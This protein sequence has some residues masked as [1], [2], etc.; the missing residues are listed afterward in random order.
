MSGFVRNLRYAARTLLR[1]P[2]FTAAAIAT[3]ALG[4][5][6]CTV[7]FSVF[8]ALVLRPLPFA[9]ASRLVI[10]WDQ[11]PKLG[12]ERLAPTA[13]NYFDYREQSHAFED[14]AAFQ[15]SEL[16]LNEVN[17]AG[18]SAAAPERIQALTVSSNIFSVLGVRPSIGRPF[19]AADEQLGRDNVVLLSNDLWR[20]R[21]GGDAR[22][23]GTSVRLNDR[24]FQ[25]AGVM[26]PDFR[27]TIDTAAPDLWVPLPLTRSTSHTVGA[28]A[29]L[30]RGFSLRQAQSDMNRVAAGV[31]AAYRPYNGPHGEDAGYRVRVIE[32]RDQLFGDYKTSAWVLFGAVLFVLLIACA[33]VANLLVARRLTR[34]REFAIRVALGA[35]RRHLLGE[36]TAEAI[37]VAACGGLL[38]VSAARWAIQWLPALIALPD[39]A[40][41]RLDWRVALFALAIASLTAVLFEL[42]GGWWIAMKSRLAGL[43]PR[44]PGGEAGASRRALVAIEVALAIVL[45]TGAGLLLKS[46]WQLQQ[47]RPGFDPHGVLTMRITL[48]AYKYVVPRQRAAFFDS[49]TT[50]LGTLPGVESAAVVSHLPLSGGGT[51]GDP[52]S[53]EGRPYRMNGAAPQVAA[54]YVA[55]PGYFRTMRIPLLAGRMLDSRDGPDAP[56]AAIVSETLARGFWPTAADALGKRI[57]LGA[58]QPG[59]PWLT[60]AGI[61][62]DIRN[63]GLR[64]APIPQIYVAEAQNPPADMFVLLRTDRDPMGL[65]VAARRAVGG[66]DP[67][68]PVYGVTTMDQRVSGS[69]GRDRFQAI[70][71]GVFAFAGLLLASIGIYG[72]LEHSISDRIPEIGVRM[73]VGAQRSDILKLLIAQGMA[74]TLIGM[75]AGLAAAFALPPILRSLLFGASANDPLMLLAAALVFTIVAL[76]ACTLPARRA[77]RIDPASALRWD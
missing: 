59:A 10:V 39:Q 75:A 28:I 41:I 76:I 66:I 32:L 21:F 6:G 42:A 3:L 8:D 30:K 33:N 24:L 47:V 56:P 34:R 14:M 18:S 22:V 45:L 52:F 31:Q 68:Q 77:M 62:G 12:I 49:I 4:I 60:I 38:G 25:I 46:F 15:F 50:A 44:I 1:A 65:A 17:H 37:L 58:P 9:N 20:R 63:S 7:V 55:S 36:L 70:L 11:L 72:V 64:T 40:R 16:N 5:A 54:Y 27:F 61:A 35:G 71:L 19:N 67:D 23:V 57:V 73:A 43:G 2:G 74:P 48:P 53:I 26:P 69:I 29:T 13:S 51:G